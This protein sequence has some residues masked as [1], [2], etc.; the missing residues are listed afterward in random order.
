ML[1]DY[2]FGCKIDNCYTGAISYADDITLSCPSIRG[3]NRMLDICNKFAAEHYLIFCKKSLAIKYGNEVNG[4]DYVLLGQN[5]INWVD[6]VKHLGNTQL[7][8]SND[9]MMKRS[10]SIG[11]A[12]KLMANFA[13][14]KLPFLRYFVVIFMGL[15]FLYLNFPGF[16]R[17]CT[18]WNIGVRTVFKLSF[19]K[20]FLGSLLGQNLITSKEY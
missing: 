18:T 11:S 10:T 4:I 14:F 8:D 17:I 2:G 3:W 15:Q 12:N 20:Y 16:R 7:S 6:S 9:C 1:R 19:T 5:K 13:H